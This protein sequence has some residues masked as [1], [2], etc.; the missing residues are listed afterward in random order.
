MVKRGCPA[1]ESLQVLGKDEETAV[2]D[3][4][5]S[6]TKGT[7]HLLGVEHVVAIVE[8]KLEELHF[9]PTQKLQ[10]T[11]DIFGGPRTIPSGS[12]CESK[13]NEEFDNKVSE[14]KERW[15]EFEKNTRETLLQNL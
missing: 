1:L 15:E 6:E 9:P 13:S 8:K 10:I 14:I 3:G 11:D 5:L 2:Y 4:I 12:L 7:I